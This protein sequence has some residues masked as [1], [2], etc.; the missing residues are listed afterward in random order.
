VTLCEGVVGLA[1][2]REV[3]AIV[4]GIALAGVPMAAFNIWLDYFIEQQGR[5]EVVSV[6][7]RALS[8]A[9]G[10][11][12]RVVASLDGLAERGVSSCQPAQLEALRQANFATAPV[13]EFSVV[14]A[15]GQTLC[16][17]LGIPLGVRKVV[18]S[19]PLAA[20]F[21]IEVLHLA[22]HREPVVRIRR[23]GPEGSNGLAALVPS[24]LFVPQVSTQGGPLTS[25]AV[26]AT[27][28]GSAIAKN[29][30]AP[31]A[32]DDS[33][34]SASARSERFNL[35]A[36][37][38]LPRDRV[39]AIH[40][41]LH[42]FGTVL[43]SIIALMI[44][45]LALLVPARRRGDAVA[46]IERAVR[47]GEFVP[48]C[49]PIV[50][51]TTGK[52]YGAEVLMRWQKP[53]GSL[54]LPGAFI[55][56]LESSGLILEATRGLMRRARD[57]LGAAYGSRPTLRLSFNLAAAHFA[58]EQIVGDVRDLFGN[59]P[60]RFN[61]VVLEL[62]ERQPIQNLT[63][64]RRIIAAL[65]GLGVVIAIDDVGTGH[66]GLSYMLKLGVD[67]IK[68]DKLFVDAIGT[69]GNSATIIGTLIDLAQNMRMDIVA[70]GVES[71]E[72]VVLLR[73][74]GIRAA[75]GYVFAPPLP[76][77]SFLQ[78]VEAIDPLPQAPAQ[79]PAGASRAVA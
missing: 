16:S 44:L 33:G 45:A 78:L 41:D 39:L 52:L 70:E 11:L 62:T 10:R 29:G 79:S 22:E 75:Q 66:S 48:Y 60:I 20:G 68:I 57:E 27:R 7:K 6:T 54:A 34:F 28:E 64:T 38:T 1:R 74:L 73:D 21:L 2:K 30:I 59:S 35:V 65:Q 61:Q 18:S 36:S 53:N 55:P 63:E 5:E 19:Q 25:Y 47:A 37:V 49:Q 58:N 9:D 43:T 67:L 31:P 14:D 8:I 72:Q 46:E 15:A 42:Q 77:S 40:S 26:L 69:D 13:K 56:I 23:L 32:D 3:L 12:A 4:I 51:I 71:F 76:V 24:Y 17:D 50:D